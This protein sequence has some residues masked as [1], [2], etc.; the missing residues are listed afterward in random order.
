M[1]SLPFW[2][3][4]VYP[5]SEFQDAA[6]NLY[7]YRSYTTELAKIR[8]GYLMKDIFDR[9]IKKSVGLLSPDCAVW[10]YSSHDSVMFNLIMTM[11]NIS[12]SYYSLLFIFKIIIIFSIYLN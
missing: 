10:L 11:F 12:V 7:R 5:S 3:T 4:K 9:S 8:S 1:F 2:T 6:L